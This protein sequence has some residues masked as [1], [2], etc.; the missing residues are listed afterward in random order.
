MDTEHHNVLLVTK[1]SKIS[2]FLSTMLV[3][4]LFS[5]ETIS[6]TNFARRKL[7]ESS[8][9]IVIIDS[10]DGSDTDT[11]I[12]ISETNSTILLL[13]P[14]HLFDQISYRVEPYGILTLSKPF[15]AFY[16]Y[17]IIKIAIAVQHKISALTMESYRLKEKMEEI[18][19]VNRAKMLLISS[20]NMSEKE[21]HR[22]IEKEAMDR[23][24][25]RTEVANQIIRTYSD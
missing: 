23:C 16:F 7:V 2:S 4:P 12:D 17:N 13:A 11:A 22:Y 24:I 1:D 20:L 18:R 21:A 6:D 25:K 5:L 19:T 3:E 8:S 15:D 14:N 10:G 9:D